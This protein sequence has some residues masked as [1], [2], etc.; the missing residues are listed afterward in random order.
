MA[1]ADSSRKFFKVLKIGL[2]TPKF[3]GVHKMI[4]KR[5]DVLLPFTRSPWQA[6]TY[7]Q[8]S[9]D[10]KKSSKSYVYSSLKHFVSNDILK[11]E[12]I[13]NQ[14]L[15]RLRLD[16][17]KALSAVGFLLEH[18]THENK[19]IPRIAL[20]RLRL[21]MP[22]RFHIMLIAGSYAK[23][24]QTPASDLDLIIICDDRVQPAKVYAELRHEAQLSV[25]P[26]HLQVFTHKEF[27]A[28]L[29]GK[30]PNLA[31]EAVDGP[32]VFVGGSAYLS[33]IKEAIDHGFSG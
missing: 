27:L 31:K 16:S 24:K 28:M 4:N 30:G 5:K 9:Q 14:I 8:I 21:L 1:Q 12:A 6:L 15:Y 22:T 2:S 7:K 32:L 3:R 13:G 19:R 20:E 33:L 26:I 23:N 29:L 17:L 11:E 18:I 10:S 25:P